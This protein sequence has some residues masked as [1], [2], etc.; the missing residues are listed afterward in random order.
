MEAFR[1]PG[2]HPPALYRSVATLGV[3]DGVH[4]GHQRVL[5]EVVHAARQRGAP[6][7]VITFDR[8][9]HRVL[10]RSPQ[11]AITSLEHRLRLFE[12]L[13]LDHCMVISFAPEIAGMSAA[14]FARTVFRDLLHVELLIVGPDWRFGRDHE[15]DVELCRRMAGELGLE[16]HVV[17]PVMVGEQ[18][19]SSTRIRRAIRAAAFAD[20]KGLLGRPFSLF[21]TVV[22]GAGRG[23]TLGYPTANL[24]VHNELLP[25]QG[26]YATRL[27]L[28]QRPLP[29]V[30]SVGRRETFEQAGQPPVVAEVHV[31]DSAADLYGRD[32]E[33]QFVTWLRGQRRFSSSEALAEQIGRDVAQSRAV[34][35]R[36]DTSS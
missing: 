30:T 5:R 14:D 29:S 9:P 1:W 2:E 27:L 23:R 8:H 17:A 13:G 22:R 36:E 12:G 25:R 16:A 11:P 31:L 7:V 26:V 15:G 32:V 6:S 35:A 10:Q 18:V 21:G 34:L 19:V 24:D 33:V 28:G 20:V 3:F 4:V